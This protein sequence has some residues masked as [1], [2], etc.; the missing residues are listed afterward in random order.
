MT[1]LQ[2]GAWCGLSHRHTHVWKNVG[3]WRWSLLVCHL[4]IRV[5]GRGKTEAA[6]PRSG[7]R[8]EGK[9]KP[10]QAYYRGLAV[11]SAFTG[12]LAQRSS[13]RAVDSK[14]PA[15]SAGFGLVGG[16][17]GEVHEIYS[18]RSCS[19]D[20]RRFVDGYHKA[21]GSA[22]VASVVGRTAGCP[23]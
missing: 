23:P 11:H 22:S 1:E 9:G 7:R 13:R 19:P 16:N 3:P 20:C 2:V 6:V 12:R 4:Q 5:R 8:G 17:Q 18:C 10:E 21:V 14:C 15:F